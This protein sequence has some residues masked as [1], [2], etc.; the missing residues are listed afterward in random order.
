MK[1][2]LPATLTTL[3]VG[4]ALFARPAAAQQLQG[5]R[6]FFGERIGI[7]F[8]NGAPQFARG[9][10]TTVAQVTGS[11]VCDAG[12][13]LQFY[14]DGQRVWNRQHQV[15]PNGNIPAYPGYSSGYTTLTVPVPGQPKL[16]HVFTVSGLVSAGQQSNRDAASS[17]L[18]Y[19]T[20]DMSRDQGMGD[21]MPD[22]ARVPLLVG[23]A[24]GLT[25]LGTRVAAHAAIGDIFYTW[26][27]TS[28]GIAPPVISHAGIAFDSLYV[29]SSPAGPIGGADYRGITLKSTQ[30][31]SEI[32]MTLQQ[33]G[34]IQLFPFDMN[35]GQVRPVRQQI[36]EDRVTNPPYPGFPSGIAYADTTVEA[37]AYS[38]DLTRL[39][40]NVYAPRLPRPG[41][42]GLIYQYDLT[43]PDSASLAAS[44]VVVY[45]D[46]VSIARGLQI[47]PDGLLYFLSD[48]G[49]QQTPVAISAGQLNVITCPNERG[50]ACNVRRNAVPYPYIA[51]ALYL[52]VLNQTF[53]RNAGRLQIVP[54]SLTPCLGDTVRLLAIGAGTTGF[55]WAAGPGIPAGA[56]GRVQQFVPTAIGSYTFS[57]TGTSTCGPPVVGGVTL[58]VRSPPS[59]PTISF[60]GGV[61]VTSGGPNLQW[62]LNGVP[63]PGANSLTYQP[64]QSGTYAVV[65]GQI[66]TAQSADLVVVLTGLADA[67]PNDAALAVWPNP[68]TGAV[69]LRLAEAGTVRLLDA[70]G[71]VVRETYAAAGQE[72]AWELTGVAPGLYLVRAGS[73]TRRLVVER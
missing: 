15:M 52:P 21:V 40:L 59:V 18:G 1:K 29:A 53:F 23:V 26:L 69:R 35:T 47:G 37:V 67:G 7:D 73:A 45:S 30:T 38:P 43:A 54:S 57:V 9:G 42:R 70:V 62:L 27:V 24:D 16:Y 60:G 32:A 63:I 65:I 4:L 11:S 5:S 48:S 12:G 49:F 6:W 55:T 25:V 3:L 28:Q 20:V 72:V 34:L 36:L 46:T 61:L 64:T 22:T 68:A 56:T 8:T 14:T 44:R 19:F 51:D 33:R 31:S 39:Y 58:Q 71:R 13:Q 50:T 10:Q 2:L 17:A 66:C 41:I